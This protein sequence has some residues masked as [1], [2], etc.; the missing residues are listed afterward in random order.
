MDNI[1]ISI[2]SSCSVAY[3]LQQN[4]CRYGAFP[5]DWTRTKKLSS[6]TNIIKNQFMHFDEFYKI[7]NVKN[8]P[9]LVNDEFVSNV[10]NDDENT[11]T[12]HAKNI[13]DVHSFHDFTSR[14]PFEDQQND[15]I[16]KYKRRIDRFYEALMSEKTIVFI[17]DELQPHKLHR[18]DIVDFVDAIKEINRDIKYKIIIVRRVLSPGGEQLLLDGMENI[19]I[20]DDVDEFDGWKRNNVDWRSIF[21]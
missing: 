7:K 14:M 1:Y 11:S 4:G 9:L 19:T 15:V 18:H 16:E 17:R 21:R 13:Y 20:V 8:H 10:L 5:F 3:Q 2:G 12:I 6:I